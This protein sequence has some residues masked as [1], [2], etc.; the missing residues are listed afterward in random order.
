[1]PQESHFR[2]SDGNPRLDPPDTDVD[3]LVDLQHKTFRYFLRYY[4]P[5]TGLIADNSRDG[6][7]C[8]IT[9]VGL[10]LTAYPIGV[11]R[12]YITRAEAIKRT[13]TTLRFFWES[14]HSAAPDATGYQG[15]YYHFLDMETGRR[16]GES[17]LSTVDTSFLL[18]GALTAAHYFE[19]DTNAEREIRE[20]ADALYRRA[21]WQW[22]LNGDILLSHGWLPEKGFLQYHWEGYAEALLMYV[23]GLGSPTYPLPDASY[24]KWLKTYRWMR[25][26][27]YEYVHAG[28]L[29]IHQLSH[30]WI[31]FR[32]IQDAYMH[33][34]GIDYFENSRRAVYVQQEYAR[35]NPRNFT[36]YGERAWG[37]T[38]SD[39]PGNET[40][41]VDGVER[42][43]YAYRARGIP[44]GPDDGTLSPWAVV[45]SLPFAPELVI[46]TIRNFD[47]QYPEM[48]SEMGF[49][50]SFNPTYEVDG[51]GW[52]AQGYYG[53]D[54]GPIVL[55]IENFLTGFTW[56]LLRGSPH[57]I[58]GLRRAGFSGGWLDAA[59][60]HQ[61]D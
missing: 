40:R 54:Q 9:A 30:V 56:R 51:S 39:G 29:F 23:L 50:C 61:T 19:R 12:G 5:T 7:P 33:A 1:M 27:G 58:H 28:P 2:P 3:M 42:R 18:A 21:N 32:N 43:F 8:S 13:L 37:I 22:A 55:M 17:E 49:R 48:S 34:R 52:V 46:P 60:T 4:N 20:L 11:Q 59:A 44:H 26:Y 15:F 53:L 14:P 57:I 36:G 10:A 41:I 35:R 31:D 16:H 47:E 25:L 24:A 45:A 6:A 38:A